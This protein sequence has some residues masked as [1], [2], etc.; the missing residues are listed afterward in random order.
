MLF[1]GHHIP[2][3]S[4]EGGAMQ[5]VWGVLPYKLQARLQQARVPSLREAA[6]ETTF[7]GRESLTN[8][9]I[10]AHRTSRRGIRVLSAKSL[11][12]SRERRAS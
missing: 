10:V 8:D 12:S 7:E 5:Q 1:Q 4:V 2:V 6:R 9:E 3:G 11:S